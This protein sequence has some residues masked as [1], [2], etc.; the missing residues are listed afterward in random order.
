MG[1]SVAFEHRVYTFGIYTMYHRYRKAKEPRLSDGLPYAPVGP[2]RLSILRA[3]SGI[4]R[5]AAFARGSES[6]SVPY[7]MTT[8]VPGSAG[9][10]TPLSTMLLPVSA[11]LRAPEGVKPKLATL[12]VGARSGLAVSVP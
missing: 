6:G 4:P 1:S 2:S 11:K 8:A 9:N 3:A 10:C 12:N 7:R 5:A